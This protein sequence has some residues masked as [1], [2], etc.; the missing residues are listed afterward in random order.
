M[1]LAAAAFVILSAT[2]PSIVFANGAIFRGEGYDI[3]P[4]KTDDIAMHKEIVEMV[5]S[6][7]TGHIELRCSFSFVNYGDTATVQMGFPLRAIDARQPTR[8][9]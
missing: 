8:S 2:S 7:K 3:L 4:A 1:R 5:E 9:S 6:A